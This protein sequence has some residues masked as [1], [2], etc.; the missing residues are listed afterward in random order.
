MKLLRGQLAESERLETDARAQDS[1]RGA[2]AV[3]LSGD[4]RRAMIDIRFREDTVGSVKR[5][6]AALAGAPVRSLEGD[7]SQYLIAAELY[8]MAGRPD[9]ARTV[10][11]Q[12]VGGREG[13]GARPFERAGVPQSDG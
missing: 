5:L 4:L 13:F 9:R 8:A 12:Y 10:L 1:A 7:K 6:D 11:G 2:P 3:A